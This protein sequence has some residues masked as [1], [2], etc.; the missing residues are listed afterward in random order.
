MRYFFHSLYLPLRAMAAFGRRR[1][2]NVQAPKG[3]L[4]P[5]HS[6][7]SQGLRLESAALPGWL[8]GTSLLAVAELG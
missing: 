1:T 6:L 2:V 3:W 8:P 5:V 7:L 4:L